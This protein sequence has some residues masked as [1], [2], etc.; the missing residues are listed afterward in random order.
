[1]Q[2]CNDKKDKLQ[3]LFHRFTSRH[4]IL[5]ETRA[6]QIGEISRSDLFPAELAQRDLDT[7]RSSFLL[8]GPNLASGVGCQPDLRECVLVA[9]LLE[10]DALHC[11]WIARVFSDWRVQDH[12]RLAV[13][14]S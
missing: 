3:R 10:N 8:A 2:E 11:V 13:L 5:S 12:A 4:T 9:V 1:E 6:R 14:A 7:L